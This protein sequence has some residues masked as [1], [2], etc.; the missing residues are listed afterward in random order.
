[1]IP[2]LSNFLMLRACPGL[3]DEVR[4]SLEARTVGG[5]SG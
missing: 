1:M 3:K 2:A 5:S 4:E